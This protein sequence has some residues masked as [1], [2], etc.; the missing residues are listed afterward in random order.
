MKYILALF[1]VASAI[2][3]Q[4][5]VNG[6][7]TI[8]GTLDV[9]TGR[10]I[11]PQAT[12]AA[13]PLSP[14]DGQEFTFTDAAIAGTCSGGGTQ[15]A[16]C[17]WNT[18]TSA[19]QAVGG[20]SGGGSGSPGGSPGDVQ[21]NVAG[22]FGTCTDAQFGVGTAAAYL[23]FYPANDS[24]HSVGFITP[25]LRTTKL[26]MILPGGDPVAGSSPELTAPSSGLSTM[27]FV[28]KMNMNQT[29]GAG[30][31]PVFSTDPATCSYGDVI[32]NSTS[33][34]YRVCSTVANAW[35]NLTAEVHKFAFCHNATCA[36]DAVTIAD[37]V[38][39]ASKPVAAYFVVGTAPTTS[40]TVNCTTSTGSTLFTTAPDLNTHSGVFDVT[41]SLRAQ[42]FT[43]LSTI[44]G[45]TLTGTTGKD[46]EL[47]I[48][49]R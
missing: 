19:W 42:S 27:S 35:I 3:A 26:Q 8:Y 12:F 38:R 6:S 48:E 7:R 34:T 14:T 47:Y 25:T 5:V 23:D 39:R 40:V 9:S 31:I 20:G 45:C 13:P 29:T 41:S 24:V 16:K 11:P 30:Q 33:G 22:A 32:A 15:L 10:F 37:L 1:L 17:R 36:N 18:T 46:V 43:D 49:T 28:K 4:Q 2:F 44:G 21:C